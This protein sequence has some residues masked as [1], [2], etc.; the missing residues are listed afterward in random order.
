MNDDGDDAGDADASEGQP[1]PAAAKGKKAAGAKT[2]SPTKKAVSARKTPVKANAGMEEKGAKNGTRSKR[3]KVEPKKEEG[4]KLE[5]KQE[6]DDKSGVMADDEEDGKSTYLDRDPYYD[7]DDN[8]PD[9]IDMELARARG[10]EYE[11]YIRVRE[12]RGGYMTPPTPGPANLS[13]EDA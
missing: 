12:E 11:E 10:M 5:P 8:G 13:D 3:A 7:S 2:G 4:V 6:E 1:M 9:R